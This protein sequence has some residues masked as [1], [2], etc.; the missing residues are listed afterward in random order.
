MNKKIGESKTHAELV[1]VMGGIAIEVEYRESG[2]DGY[3]KKE[4]VTVRELGADEMLRYNGVIDFE[5]STAELFCDKPQ[6]WANTITRA[7]LEKILKVGE[8]DV[9]NIG[10]QTSKLWPMLTRG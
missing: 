9:G 7:S 2:P 1:S 3:K 5:G 4:S 8:D 10:V 6:G